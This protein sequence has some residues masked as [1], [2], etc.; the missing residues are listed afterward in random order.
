MRRIIRTAGTVFAAIFVLAAVS[1]CGQVRTVESSSPFASFRD[2]PGITA[3]EIAA[4][5]ALRDKYTHFVYG[6]DHTI[7]AFPVHMGQDNEVGGYAARFCE[8]LTDLFGI[9]FIPALYMDDWHNLMAE[10][11]SGDVHFMGDLMPTEGRRGTHFMTGTISERSLTAFQIAGSLPIAEIARSRPPR[12][13]FPRDYVLHT[14]TVE[15]A[16]FVFE[17]VFV[18]SYAHAYSVIASGE[19]DA[20]VTMHTAEPTLARYGDVVGETF[21]PLVFSSASLSTH[22]RDLAPVISVVQKALESGAMSH[23]IKLHAQGR[24]DYLKNELFRRLTGE[25]LDYIRSN[26]I[27]KIVA[28]TANYPISF[29]NDNENEF[30]GIALDVLSELEAITG[31][32]FEIADTRHRSFIFGADML[33][34]GEVSMI[35]ELGTFKENIGRFLWPQTP[36]MRDHS[37]LIS[38]SEFPDV[39]FNELGNVNVGMVSATG[40]AALFRGW[41]PNNTGYKEYDNSDSAFNA[42]ERGEIDILLSRA[43]YLLSL[44]NYREIAGYKANTIFDNNFNCFFGFNKDEELLCAIVDKALALIDMEAISGSWTHK[45]FDYRAKVTKAR[46]PWLIGATSLSLITLALILVL[47]FRARNEGKRLEALVKEET[48]TLT[49]ILNGTPDHIFCK[50][51]NSNYTRYNKSFRDYYNLNESVTGKFD[52]EALGL[53]SDV[54]V[55]HKSM[56]KKVFTEG[57]T[58]ISEILMP[59]PDGKKTLFE[60]IKSPLIQD[61]HITGLVGMARDITRRKVAEETAK[62][63]SLDAMKAYAEAETASEAKSRFIANM[64]HE[65][66]TPMNVIVGLTDLMLEEDNVSKEAKETLKKISTAGT[67]LMG[68]INDILDI[69]K[70]ESGK[71]NLI[72]VQ[73]DVASFLNDIIILNMIRIESKPIT[74]KL[75][76]NE[77]LPVSLFG[78]DL[79]VKQIL[80]NLLSNAFKYTKRGNVTLGV[81]CSSDSGGVWMSYCVSDTGIGI[82]KEDIAK[83][84]TDY[85]QVDTR[86]N[87]EIKGTGLGLS[88]TRKFVE[89]MDGEISVESEYGKGTAFRVRIRQGF[90]TDQP[91]GKETAENL[92]NFRYSEGKKQ[93]QGKLVRADLSYAKV[94][95]VDDFPTNLD[96]ATGM[97]RKYNM[98]VDCVL[99]GQE[100]VD[101]IS[102]GD[103][104]YD[105]IFMDHMMPGMD[106]IEATK[107]IRELGTKYA[108][109]IPIIAMTANVVAG[110]EQMF[111]S[112][113]FNAFLPKPFNVMLLDSIVQRWV[114]DKSRE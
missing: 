42:L 60:V 56:D 18:D 8:W 17:S 46:L 4:I 51:L 61:G 21:F 7:E 87:R 76:I 114:R 111:L 77:N 65:I 13:A 35:T 44:E 71:Q 12:L 50:D 47:F 32:S 102:A 99:S 27:V 67:T 53:P 107:A 54:V 38:K 105:A 45:T 29:Y 28:E 74:F 91:I 79:R 110:N 80:N 70:I 22:T 30:E 83:L 92:R 108:E 19:A 104:V 93:A 97:L 3:E 89:L 94:L 14:H 9:P 88:I 106:G 68:L 2:V 73:Y 98:H 37:V 84:F 90:V 15:T 1:G 82:R 95:V 34:R 69:S 86:A 78:D 39:Y 72:P 40:H 109:N 96:V 81:D 55:Y 16:E 58:V 25:E 85:N 52:S 113:G 24:Y 20:F 23:L 62:K 31:L 10:F 63:A 66:R 6:V 75:E 49:A 36:I 57:E 33:E 100:S 48:S 101:R 41:F 5:E 43:N 26:P 64:S 59:S 103:P 112:N 11:E